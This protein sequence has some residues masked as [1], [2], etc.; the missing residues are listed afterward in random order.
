MKIALK[1]PYFIAAAASGT[2]SS[3]DDMILIRAVDEM[4]RSLRMHEL[5]TGMDQESRNELLQKHVNAAFDYYSSFSKAD[6]ARLLL[7][8][9]IMK[10]GGED[11]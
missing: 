2:A 1:P 8:E 7:F 5:A 11:G 10:D 4:M 3:L 6:M 9:S